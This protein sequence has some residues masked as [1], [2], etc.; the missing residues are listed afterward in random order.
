MLFRIPPT[1]FR[2][3]PKTNLEI[4][5]YARNVFKVSLKSDDPLKSYETANTRELK[6]DVVWVCFKNEEIRVKATTS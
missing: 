1:Y 6:Y 5:C 2:M 4:Y 3:A